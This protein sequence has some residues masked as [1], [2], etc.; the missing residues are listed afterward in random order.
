MAVQPNI[1]LIRH[2]SAA[3]KTRAA[4]AQRGFAATLLPLS[5]IEILDTNP[6]AS[7]FDGLVFTSPVAPE[8]FCD[9]LARTNPQNI[10]IASANINELPI[11]CVG[12]I[13]ALMAQKTGFSNIAA[14][15]ENSQ[16]LATA[17]GESA[18]GNTLLYPCARH[19]SFDFGS[20]LQQQGVNCLNWEIYANQFIEPELDEVIHALEMT[21]ALMLFS[22]RTSDHFFKVTNSDSDTA[23]A[24]SRL[25]H[26][27]M[28]AI[29]AKVAACIPRIFQTNIY[30]AKDKNENSMIECLE[31]I[32]RPRKS[33]K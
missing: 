1:L 9:Q 32:S 31:A 16:T 14:I 22:K 5:K 21:D 3:E 24:K 10:S 30:I 8:I 33:P 6:P 19:R 17:I 29:S 27:S 2:Q 23:S 4:L 13:T 18:P 20:H 11:Y 7:R 26:H 28:V 12:E 15:G 25:A